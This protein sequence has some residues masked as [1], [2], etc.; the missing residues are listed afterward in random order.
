MPATQVWFEHADPEL[1]QAPELLQVWGCWALHC[2]PPGE[3]DPEHVPPT[4]AWFEQGAAEPQA[5]AELHV[6]TPLPEH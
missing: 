3:H 2:R 5:P 4:Q 6:S 1:C